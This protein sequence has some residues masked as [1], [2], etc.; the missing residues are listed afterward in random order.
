MFR[1]LGKA[2]RNN[3]FLGL[4]LIAPVGLTL[5]IAN[6]LFRFF[7]GFLL[8]RAL[9]DSGHELPLRIAALLLVIVVCFLVG[10][11]ARSLLGKK[12]YRIGDRILAGLPGLNRI[13]IH[14]RH[15]SEVLIAQRQALFKEVVVVEY[16]RK[17][18][19]S[20][21]FLTARMPPELDR[22]MRGPGAGG[23]L[24]SI[25]VPTTPNPTSGLMILVPRSDVRSLPLNVAEAMKLIISG[26]AV[27][28]GQDTV[29]QRPTLLDKLE[30]LIAKEAR[31]EVPA[32]EPDTPPPPP[33]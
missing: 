32:A 12:L 1:K 17:G 27:L 10:S 19:F 26:G 4:A 13:Y 22:Q 33:A 14:I 28:P 21:G 8:P 5:I 11:I 24:V 25:F 31:G 2:L 9:H 16:P 3:F 15:I 7:T 18:I 6:W 23:E 20:I 29:D 30:A